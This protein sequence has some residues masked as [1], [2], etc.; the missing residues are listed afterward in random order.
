MVRHD[1]YIYISLQIRI[2]N[3][4][5]FIN[6]IYLKV[7]QALMTINKSIYHLE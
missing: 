5:L 7:L 6:F 4:D 2:I 3:N 1:I